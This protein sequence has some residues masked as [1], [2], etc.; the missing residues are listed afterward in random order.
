MGLACTCTSE[1]LVQGNHVQKRDGKSDQKSDSSAG[2]GW[3]LD[4]KIEAMW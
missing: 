1:G 3:G 4:S 2:S